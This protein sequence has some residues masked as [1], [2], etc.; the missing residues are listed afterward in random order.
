MSTSRVQYCTLGYCTKGT[1]GTVYYWS[2]ALLGGAHRHSDIMQVRNSMERGSE[3]G[4]TELLYEAN[5]ILV[6]KG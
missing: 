2:T 6:R 5:H 3:Q 4:T 1:L